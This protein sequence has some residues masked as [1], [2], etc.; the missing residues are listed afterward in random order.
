MTYSAQ[1]DGYR[2]A[3]SVRYWSDAYMRQQAEKKGCEVEIAQPNTLQI[4]IDSEEAYAFFEQQIDVLA[5]LGTV[6]FETYTVRPSKNGLPRRHI[7]VLL[8][9]PLP[10]ETRIL[11][12]AVLGSD[13]KR[14][15]LAYTG[16]LRG[17]DNPVVFFR[18]KAKAA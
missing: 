12:Q 16:F 15:L 10:M 11:L 8:T 13:R 5:S 2:S 7:T 9:E 17:Q 14:E 4:D 3:E 6:D 1:V 18:P